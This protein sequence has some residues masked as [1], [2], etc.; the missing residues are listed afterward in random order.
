M[1]SFT[2]K[3]LTQKVGLA[4]V[5]TTLVLA[6]EGVAQRTRSEV[7]YITTQVRGAGCSEAAERARLEN[8]QGTSGENV[9]TDNGGDDNDLSFSGVARAGGIPSASPID[10]DG[11]NGDQGQVTPQS[12]TIRAFVI[13]ENRQPVSNVQVILTRATAGSR[14]FQQVQGPVRTSRRGVA[15]FTIDTEPGTSYEYRVSTVSTRTRAASRIGSVSSRSV[16]LSFCSPGTGENA[17]PGFQG[18]DETAGA[19][20]DSGTGI[21]NTDVNEGTNDANRTGAAPGRIGSVPNTPVSTP[22]ISST[23]TPLVG[24]EAEI[25]SGTRTRT[26]PS[27][28][29]LL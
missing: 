28:V 9:I 3:D 1:H 20:P 22:Q 2:L 17:G 19:A 21:E 24:P 5:A 4:L 26:S 12:C 13:G 29:T 18:Q 8:G 10:P 6:T 11:T 14:S 27:G 16:G 15:L 7:A 25:G 23:S